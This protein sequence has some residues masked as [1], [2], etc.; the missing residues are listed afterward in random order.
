MGWCKYIY[1]Q[2]KSHPEPTSSSLGSPI[3]V[4]VFGASGR[5]DL[6]HLWPG[7]PHRCRADKLSKQQSF[8][9]LNLK[10]HVSTDSAKVTWKEKIAEIHSSLLCGVGS[11]LQNAEI[12]SMFTWC[13][14]RMPSPSLGYLQ[15]VG[16]LSMF[17]WKLIT[18]QAASWTP[19]NNGSITLKGV[20]WGPK[21]FDKK[22][23]PSWASKTPRFLKNWRVENLLSTWWMTLG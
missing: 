10:K 1:G 14:H 6:W 2:L 22:G 18:R 5:G 12:P 3:S 23:E 20:H 19:K 4:T 8:Y 21:M 7:K 13:I 17:Q 9:L 16:F 15:L 11:A